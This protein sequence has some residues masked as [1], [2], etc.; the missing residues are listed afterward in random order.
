[1]I[2][3]L[4]FFGELNS[5]SLKDYTEID[6]V[7]EQENIQLDINFEDVSIDPDKLIILKRYLEEIQPIIYI[8]KKE[9]LI[10]FENGED[11]KEF[12]NFHIEELDQDDMDKILK[13][14]D[15]TL[16]VEAR[17]LSRIKLKRIGFYPYDDNEFAILDFL[18]DEDISQYI[19]VVKMNSNKTVDHIT[20]E[21]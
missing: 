15:K 13:H 12:L 19:L 21:S 1:M 4:P 20:M 16:S 2:I 17:I 7:I 18:L 11:V 3:N 8:A 9:I 6:V 5:Y 10:D 14:T